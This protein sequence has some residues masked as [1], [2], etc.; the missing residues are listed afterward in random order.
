MPRIALPPAPVISRNTL[1]AVQQVIALRDQLLRTKD[2]ADE[3]TAGGTDK[4]A[5][6]SSPDV[7]GTGPALPAG[8]GATLYDAL[9][10]VLAAVNSASV[11]AV[12]KT[13]D[14]G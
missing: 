2:I 11:K 9:V 5:L 8:T 14:R 12:V 3:I 6:E 13:F 4:A 7:V 1:S 10:T